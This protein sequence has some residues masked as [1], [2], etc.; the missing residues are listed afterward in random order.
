MQIKDTDVKLG[1]VLYAFPSFGYAWVLPAGSTNVAQILF[2]RLPYQGGVTGCCVIATPTPGSSVLYRKE[3]NTSRGYIVTTLSQGS[4]NK[5]YYQVRSL[6]TS[7]KIK[8]ASASQTT[9]QVLSQVKTQKLAVGEKATVAGLQDQQPGDVYIGDRYGPGIF[10]GRGQVC[11]KG[12]DLSYMQFGAFQ[13]KIT[14]VSVKTDLY[15][16]SSMQ[17]RDTGLDKYLKAS[18]S[19][20]GLGGV[21]GKDTDIF[22]VENN[23]QRVEY[24]NNNTPLYRFQKFS[25]GVVQGV[26][27]S[28]IAQTSSGT[29]RP[30]ILSY[31]KDDYDGTST[32]FGQGFTSIKT[33]RVSGVSQYPFA[34]DATEA[35]I[36]KEEKTRKEVLKE[37][38]KQYADFIL[39][40]NGIER[41]LQL[42]KLLN[43]ADTSGLLSKDIT[44][45]DSRVQYGIDLATESYHKK[46]K[47]KNKTPRIG[48][49]QIQ[50][51]QSVSVTDKLTGRTAVR[52]DNNSIV[53]QDP[54]GSVTIK[55]G[56]GSQITM[57]HG[58]IYISSALDTFIRPGRDLITMVPRH[59]SQSANGQIEVAS[60]EDI[61]LGAQ[62]NLVMASALSGKEGYTVLENRTKLVGDAANTGVVIRS[63]GNMSI[64]ASDD[65]HIGTNDKR[66]Q[67]KKDTGIV[68]GKGSVYIDG[69]KVRI[70]SE[71][72]LRLSGN[73]IGVYSYNAASLIGTGIELAPQ[74]IAIVAPT[75]G[76]D[77]GNIQMGK[78]IASYQLA[79]GVDGKTRVT[80]SQGASD[81]NLWVRGNV[82]CSKGITAKGDIDI[83]GIVF[84]SGYVIYR[85]EALKEIPGTENGDERTNRI[86]HLFEYPLIGTANT[87]NFVVVLQPW[88][89]DDFICKKELSFFDT[90]SVKTMPQMCWQALSTS[91]Q[92]LQSVRA[93]PTGAA[94]QDFT[95]AYPGKKAWEE[96]CKMI[97]VDAT[98]NIVKEN[99]RPLLA[100]AYKVNTGGK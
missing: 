47:L 94:N 48:E 6:H 66:N 77:S 26:C 11:V 59:L 85:K 21:V 78:S 75:I 16:L 24:K 57:S 72:Q 4:Q 36:Q 68:Q 15:T 82:Y 52:F 98:F 12:S 37:L 53:T 40:D 18:G 81:L 43:D 14:T 31:K 50:D 33:L 74:N 99:E 69:N 86:N 93:V 88:Y 27:C 19:F 45:S 80:L 92:T 76:L 55:D 30:S 51:Y 7:D 22:K 95:C 56:W 5:D 3:G 32:R 8:E 96:D 17:T 23:G 20:E 29:E 63:N 89:N 79:L 70:E 73:L 87:E 100:K 2:C 64:T 9:K 90:W 13:D 35:D 58:N 25:G 38:K 42:T 62:K 83:A 46:L 10:Y 1:V 67:N 97:T 84:G 60:K 65:I 71:G 61:K 41:I 34:E 54:D 39:S 44:E 49:Q 91:N 28:V